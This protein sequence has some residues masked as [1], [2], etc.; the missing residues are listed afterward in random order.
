MGP[1]GGGC[2]RRRWGG[3]EGTLQ[4][5]RSGCLKPNKQVVVSSRLSV[6]RVQER[7]L[8]GTGQGGYSMVVHC[9]SSG[10]FGTKKYVRVVCLCNVTPDSVR[11]N[12]DSSLLSLVGTSPR[13]SLQ[14]AVC[15]STRYRSLGDFTQLSLF[16]RI[17]HRLRFTELIDIANQGH[18]AVSP[19]FRLVFG[20][21]GVEKSEAKVVLQESGGR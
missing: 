13:R 5:V 12:I 15:L 18:K 6:G 10:L 11:R 8:F 2:T 20:A 17:C 7:S 14:H 9:R 16:A 4:R 1:S 21:V 19:A 3:G